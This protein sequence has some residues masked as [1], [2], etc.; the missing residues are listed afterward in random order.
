MLQTLLRLRDLG[1]TVVVV[2]HDAETMMA[3][4]HLLDMGPGAG[5]EGG[6]V[7]AQGTPKE[8][9]KNPDSLTGSYLRGTQ[10]VS[11]PRRQRKAKGLLSI[12]GADKHNLKGVTAK[13]PLGLLTCVT[14]VS[15]S[16]KSTLVLEVLFRSLS[17]LLYHKKPKIDGCK[18]LLGVEALD[19]VIDIDQSPIGRTPRSNPATYTGLFGFI[20]DLY[21]NLPDS[22]VRGYK[23]GRYSFNVKG[24]RCEACQGDGLIKIEMHFLPDVYVTCEVCK[25]QR[26]NRETMEIHHKGESIADVLNMTVAEALLFFEHIPFIRRKLDTLNDVGL[27][28]VKLEQV[29]YNP[30]RWRGPTGQAVA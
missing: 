30:V 3:A 2:E 21:S 1:N 5:T 11:L 7:I 28:Y 13:I 19:K 8:V 10:M 22:R 6:R 27:H 16:G 26:Y 20:R 14:G 4:D 15:G 17:Q 25:G 9:M 24:Y 12:V 29:R 18:E 23:P